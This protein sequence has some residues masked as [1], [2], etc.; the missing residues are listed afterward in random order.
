MVFTVAP[1]FFNNL[2]ISR[3]LYAE[4]PPQIISNIFLLSILFIKRIHH[5]KE[6]EKKR[7]PYGWYWGDKDSRLDGSGLTYDEIE[8]IK[9]IGIYLKE[10]TDKHLNSKIMSWDIINEE[11]DFKVLEFSNCFQ[12][13]LYEN[14]FYYD[15]KEKKVIKKKKKKFLN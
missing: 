8:K 3:L 1:F 13:E 11:N 5:W 10:I 14:T 9:H 12:F 7:F 15:V 4:I 2:I 6:D